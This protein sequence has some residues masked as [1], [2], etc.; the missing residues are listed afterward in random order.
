MLRSEAC[1]ASALRA[2]TGVGENGLRVLALEPFFGG[3]HQTFLEQWQ[4]RSRHAIDILGL[5]PYHWKWRMRHSAVSFADHLRGGPAPWHVLFCSSMLDLAA[6]RGLAPAEL[7]GLPAIVY[8]HENQLTYPDNPEQERT[9][10]QRERDSHFAFT[11]ITSG[12]AAAEVWF[13][14]SY[15]QCEFL[16]ALE[17][18]EGRFPDR[19]FEVARRLAERSRTEP[20]AFDGGRGETGEPRA[21]SAAPHLVWVSRWEHDKAPERFFA[22]LQTLK[23]LGLHFELSVLGE[24]FRQVPSVFAWARETFQQELRHFG[25]LDSRA[26]YLNVLSAADFV[27]STARHEF[28]G[29]AVCEAIAAG[30]VP[31]LPRA[32]SYPELLSEMTE[33]AQAQC[34]Y[35]PSEDLVDVLQRAFALHS[36]HPVKLA[37]VQNQAASSVERFD[38]ATRLSALD[39]GIDRVA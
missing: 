23:Q 18:F 19:G 25:Y 30:C 26:E 27:V 22:A 36:E 28:F 31:V 29:L 12:L 8:F 3:S 14:S 4:V 13:N 9:A 1:L 21:S 6:F 20:P 2:G 34:L 16:A 17:E 39:A 38:W 37:E 11:H 33:W 10:S 5:P 35:P 15:H 7:S 32:L 24:S